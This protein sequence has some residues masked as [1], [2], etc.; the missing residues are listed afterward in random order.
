MAGEPVWCAEYQCYGIVKVERIGGWANKPFLVGTWHSHEH[1]TAVD[2][3]YDIEK[4]NLT[5]YRTKPLEAEKGKA[6][7][8]PPA[9]DTLWFNQRKTLEDLFN[10]WADENHAAKSCFN[11]VSFLMSQ[12]LLNVEAAKKLI[13]EKTAD[14]K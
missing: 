3:E 8:L 9:K 5:L 12:G 2:F 6:E 4:R 13:A 7:I 14:G 1:G 11:V 10:I